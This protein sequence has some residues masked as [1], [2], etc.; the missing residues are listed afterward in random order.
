MKLLI[1]KNNEESFNV[2]RHQEDHI[3][4]CDPNELKR[5]SGMD[6]DMILVSE[7]LETKEMTDALKFA[8]K[9]TNYKEGKLSRVHLIRSEK[10]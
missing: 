7:K 5:V 10:K 4:V 2:L 9:E 1:I 8:Y 3:L 6:F